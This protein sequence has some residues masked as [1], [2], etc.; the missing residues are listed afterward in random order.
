MRYIR[1]GVIVGL[2]WLDNKIVTMLST[3]HAITG[4]AWVR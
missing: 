2:Q 3:I 4:F 1:H